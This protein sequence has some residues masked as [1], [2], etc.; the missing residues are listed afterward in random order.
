MNFLRFK[1]V[2]DRRDKTRNRTNK[3]TQTEIA[4]NN[5]KATNT[6]D[7]VLEPFRFKMTSESFD[8]NQ[9]ATQTTARRDQETEPR[10][11]VNDDAYTLK[12]SERYFKSKL[13]QRRDMMLQA[14]MA[15]LKDT[16][17]DT[18]DEP[19]NALKALGITTKLALHGGA[20]GLGIGMGVTNMLLSGAINLYDAMQSQQQQ[21]EEPEE[22]QTEVIEVE[23]SPPISINSSPPITVSSSGQSPEDE[24]SSSSSS[25]QPPTPTELPMPTSPQSSRRNSR[26]SNES[27]GY[28]KKK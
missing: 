14:Y 28:P 16:P 20:L 17:S 15:P 21:E 10:V 24:R 22:N 13:Q 18:D 27:V 11:R 19:S 8:G 26:S 5:D 9:K 2:M 6:I 7:E 25:M 4:T 23:D 12:G 1:H 3:S